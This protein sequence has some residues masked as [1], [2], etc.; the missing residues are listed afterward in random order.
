MAFNFDV[1]ALVKGNVFWLIAL[2]GRFRPDQ[3]SVRGGLGEVLRILRK[4]LT[5]FSTSLISS[6]E[7][8]H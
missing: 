6:E 2:S 5:F 8:F 4:C 7:R 1:N 3:S